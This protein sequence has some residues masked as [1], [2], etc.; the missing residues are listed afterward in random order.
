MSGTV[1]GAGVAPSGTGLVSDGGIT[2]MRETAVEVGTSLPRGAASRSES[3]HALAGPPPITSNA[4]TTASR[5]PVWVLTHVVSLS[6][7]SGRFT[8]TP[9]YGTPASLAPAP[10]AVLATQDTALPRPAVFTP[11]RG[12]AARQP[13]IQVKCW[14]RG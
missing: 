13:L 10:A 3:S 5:A 9:P 4:R 11:R 7:W 1:R 8:R 14:C 2:V 6:G 12:L